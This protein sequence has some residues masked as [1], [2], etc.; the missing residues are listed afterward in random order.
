MLAVTTF[1]GPQAHISFFTKR[2]VQ[3]RAYLTEQELLE[4]YALCQILPGPTSTQTITSVG[5][6]LGGP[7]L[8]YLTLFVWAFPAVT[9]MAVVAI[10][11]SHFK[12]LGIS[13]SF[14]RYIQPMAVGFI[15][16]AAYIISSKVIKTPRAVFLM[17]ISVIIS[18][19]IRS[20]YVYP[21]IILFAG[22][23]TAIDYKKHEIEDK[24]QFNIKWLPIGLW[25]AFF[26][27]AATLGIITQWLPVRLFENFYRNGSLIF[28]GGQV[29]IPL[30][31]TEFVTFK[32]Y[33]TSQ[34]FLSGYG[35]VQAVPGPTFSFSAFIGALSMREYGT[36]GEILGAFCAAIGIFLPGTFFIFFVTRIW[37]SMKKYRVV[38][39]SLEGIHAGSSG[40]VIAA[41]L[42]LFEP[43]YDSMANGI[44]VLITVALLIWNKIPYPLILLG[45]LVAGF[46]I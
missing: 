29:L 11:I 25:G 4:L 10:L 14:T 39:A 42:I 41:A 9:I 18:F 43:M 3:K 30:L 12:D 45:G 7:L 8:A 6:K 17:L 28:G 2:L 13:L 26:L 38:K 20:P 46:I 34:E 37:D 35:V 32:S 19:A 24:A 15:A 36:M 44:V 22:F 1:G 31:H 23:I 16:Y 27:G 33:L 40:M 5:F 21:V